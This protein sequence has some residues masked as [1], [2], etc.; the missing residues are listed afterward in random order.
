VFATDEGRYKKSLNT[1]K[2]NESVLK[3]AERAHFLSNLKA[4][5]IRFTHDEIT[6]DE[7][8]NSQTLSPPADQV[9]MSTDFESGKVIQERP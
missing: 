7:V 3:R 9:R 4:S 1:N 5:S 8:L 6:K 2:Q